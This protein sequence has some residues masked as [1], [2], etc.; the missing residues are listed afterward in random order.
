LIRSWEKFRQSLITPSGGG[1]WGSKSQRGAVAAVGTVY[2]NMRWRWAN[3]HFKMAERGQIRDAMWTT[4]SL[5]GIIGKEPRIKSAAIGG[6]ADIPVVNKIE[7]AMRY[8]S[9]S[10]S[11][12]TDRGQG[13]R[14]PSFT[15]RSE[16]V[17]AIVNSIALAI[18]MTN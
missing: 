5:D 8:A 6:R 17:D 4:L 14:A 16:S 18:M 9:P 13:P 3:H 11:S 7:W 1:H 2:P 15:S 12:K 10:S